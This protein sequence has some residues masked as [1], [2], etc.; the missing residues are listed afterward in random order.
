MRALLISLCIVFLV[1]IILYTTTYFHY[2]TIR[3]TYSDIA[4]VV[5]HY[6]EN[7][8]YL[9]NEPFSEF[10]QIIYTKGENKPK[11]SS[12]ANIKQLPNV[13]VCNHTILYHIVNHYDTLHDITIFLPASCLDERKREITLQ[14]IQ[15]VKETN[16]SVFYCVA[17][18]N[19]KDDFYNFQLDKYENANSANKALNPDTYLR[20]ATIRPF[21][22]WYENHFQGIDIQHVNYT[23]IFAV[24][25]QHIHS[26]S[27]SFYRKLLEE[28]SHDK[29]EET[30]H[31][32]ERATLALF[33]PIP[34]KCIYDI[35]GKI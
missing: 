30:A 32:L 7:I 25:K 12:C 11:C 21:G 26:R 31:Y 17:Y 34:E 3:E 6:N 35:A 9:D 23:S 28:V 5:S 4:I 19:V 24:S 2:D 22:R 20:P 16:D 8:E 14:T 27:V 1:F 15:K 33:Y 10:E 18:N 29:N 13:G